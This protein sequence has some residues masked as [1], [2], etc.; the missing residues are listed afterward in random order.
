MYT[1]RM[2]PY[3]FEILAM[4]SRA[5]PPHALIEECAFWATDDERLLG[6]VI[7]DLTDRNYSFV[8]LARDENGRFRPVD[9]GRNYFTRRLAED[10][11]IK[12]MP[13]VYSDEDKALQQKE[14]ADRPL[15]L[16]HPKVSK[17]RLHPYFISLANGLHFSAARELIVEMARVFDDPDGNF[18]KDFQTTGFNS[19]LWELFLFAA[20]VEE[21]FRLNRDHS[22]P[23]FLASI[24]KETI[25]IEA[26][27][28]NPTIGK[29]GKP[30]DPPNTTN[31]D[32]LEAIR[33]HYL[34]I[35]FGSPLFQKLR[36]KDWERN[37][38]RGLPYIIAIADFHDTQ[39]IPMSSNA[40]A[41]YLFGLRVD[42]RR[43]IAG[44]TDFEYLPIKNHVWG[45][46]EIPSRFF[47]QPDAEHVSAVLFTNAGTL[48]KFNRMGV[49][50]D[51]GD[52]HVRLVRQGT[53]FDSDSQSLVPAHFQIDI[54]DPGYHERW[55]DE[56][57]LFHNF[58]AL[59]PIDRD[60]FP[61]ATHHFLKNQKI[62][63]YSRPGKIF[64][65]VTYTMLQKEADQ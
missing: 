41:S 65:S 52:S 45:S 42:F 22:Q 56:L 46:K 59:H 48:S 50:A 39:T 44:A 38:I 36:K 6:V 49:L 21:G 7:M 3:R 29:D 8:I 23:D 24:G 25:A 43:I 5:V 19:R 14:K 15:D 54:D 4:W 11:L 18:V 28:V 33:R 47:E 34:P 61:M 53:M 27:T 26:T 51:F 13:K 60:L 32:E 17:N 1:T 63:T 30:I 57:E 64:G 31:V 35:K 55:G 62:D 37:H 58:R 10:A 2:N 12:R 16:F 40:L 20:L 9:V